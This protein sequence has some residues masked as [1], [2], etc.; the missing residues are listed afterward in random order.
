MQTWTSTKGARKQKNSHQGSV[1][2]FLASWP[3]DAELPEKIPINLR[4]HC[5]MIAKLPYADLNNYQGNQK[6]G[7]FPPRKCFW[8]PCI[9]PNWC[10]AAR[11][12]SDKSQAALWDDSKISLCRLEQL[13]REPGNGKIPTKE[14]FLRSLHHAQL[15]ISCPKKFG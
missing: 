5:G 1:F 3:I 6:M 15:M 4:P 2:E 10:W 8:H 7:K 14:V 11:K 13:P 12:N 9:M